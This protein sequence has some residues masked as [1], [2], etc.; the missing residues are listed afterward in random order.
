MVYKFETF[1]FKYLPIT[2]TFYTDK[3]LHS[4][5]WV[6]FLSLFVAPCITF[7]T[8]CIFILNVHIH[9]LYN[10]SFLKMYTF[11]KFG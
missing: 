9:L 11:I 8:P 2:L 10:L 7:H 5:Y 6:F 3:T 4:F 1:K